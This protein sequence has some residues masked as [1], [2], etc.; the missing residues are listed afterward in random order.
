MYESLL[1]ILLWSSALAVGSKPNIVLVLVDD[2]EWANVGY[3]DSSSS[4]DVDTPNIDELVRQGLELDQ[5]YTYSACSPSRCSLL[6]GRLPIHVNDRNRNIALHNP[7]DPISGFAGIPRHMTTL[8]TKMKQGGYSTHV[9]GKWNVGM[10]TSNHTPEGRGFDSSLIYFSSSNDY[11]TQKQGQCNGKAI[12]D[13]WDSGS[14]AWQLSGTG[15]EESIF[16]DRILEIVDK[17]STSNPLFLYYAPHIVHTPLQVPASYL[18][19]FDHITNDDRKHYLAMVKFF[20]DVMGDLVNAL[21]A[22]GMWSNTL[23]V[24]SSDNGG[25]LSGANNYPLKGTKGSDWQGGV[26]VNAFVSGEFLPSTMHGQKT[27]GYIHL[28]DWYATFCGL[29]GVD[30]TDQLAASVGLPEIDSLNMWPL[31]S[32]QNS[33]SP[34]TDIAISLNTLISGDYK[35]LTGTVA[36]AGWTEQDHPNSNSISASLPYQSCGARGCLYNIKDDPE[37]RTNLASTNRQD[38]RTMHTKLQ[39]YQ[40]THFDPYRGSVSPAACDAALGTHQGFWGPFIQL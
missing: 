34:R 21:K 36:Q 33:T 18:T 23:L 9:V 39:A 22:R 14:P 11:Y 6:S 16:R 4:L 27:E 24:L 37:E 20:D 31:I 26:R 40:A 2:L 28:A 29:A 25:Y 15:Y 19:R 38:L 35:I 30:P 12:V 10:A 17:H 13:L 7:S 32:G 1:C 5:H 3:H 8:G